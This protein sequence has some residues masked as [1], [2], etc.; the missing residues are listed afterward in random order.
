MSN[1]FVISSSVFLH[2][3]HCRSFYTVR[4]ELT[5]VVKFQSCNMCLHVQSH[6]S[7]YVWHTLSHVRI[8]YN[9]LYFCVLYCTVLYRIQYFYFKS[10]M[11]KSKCKSSGDVAGTAKKH[12]GIMMEK[13]VKNHW[14]SGVRQKDGW[15]HSFFWYELFN[16]QHDSKEQ[17]QD[18]GIHEACC[19]SYVDNNIKV[20]WKS[21]GGDGEIPQHVDEGS[22]SASSPTQF[23]SDSRGI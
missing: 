19:V 1:M 6:V 11:S 22:T 14:E 5:Q 13:K 4:P 12:Q 3:I 23:N 9:W 10:R 20:A 16:H 8:F 21:D 7:S 17:G 15:H 2:L 18:H